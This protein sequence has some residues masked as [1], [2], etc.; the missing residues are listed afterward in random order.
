MEPND[1]VR[2]G[3]AVQTDRPSPLI[4]ARRILD[5]RYQSRVKFES[6]YA[7]FWAG[8]DARRKYGGKT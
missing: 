1:F 8:T 6:M 7:V 4:E 2:T 5:K 3:N